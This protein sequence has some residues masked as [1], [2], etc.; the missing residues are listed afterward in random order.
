[1]RCGCSGC[2]RDVRPLLDEV[3]EFKPDVIFNLV[4]TFHDVTQ[5]D[6]NITA[7]IEMLERALH[8]RVV[9]GAVP[10]QRQGAVQEDPAL[11]TACARR[12][13]TLSTAATRSGCPRR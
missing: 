12:A 10:V 7:L 3:D 1:M 11:S 2:M 5:W 9:G 4:E 13:S 6:K 8:R